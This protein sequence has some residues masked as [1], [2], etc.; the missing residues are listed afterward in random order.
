MPYSTHREATYALRKKTRILRIP[1]SLP[2]PTEMQD[3][4]WITHLGGEGKQKIG[5]KGNQNRRVRFHLLNAI[6]SVK[7]DTS[8]GTYVDELLHALWVVCTTSRTT[9]GNIPFSMTYRTEP[10]SPVEVGVLYTVAYTSMR[11]AMTRSKCADSI[12]WRKRG[13]PSRLSWQRIKGRW[14]VFIT[15]R[16]E[17][18]LYAWET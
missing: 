3:A 10:M 17:T 16:L 13:M 1:N 11:S 15:R 14:P 7:L 4:K 18:E 8:K 9:A 6:W 12:Y 2:R 5:L